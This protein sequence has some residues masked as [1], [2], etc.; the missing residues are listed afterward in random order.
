M[1]VLLG[2][3]HAA[4]APLLLFSPKIFGSASE[5]SSFDLII[6]S[7]VAVCPLLGAFLGAYFCHNQ[8]GYKPGDA[9]RALRSLC[10]LLFVGLLG[11]TFLFASTLPAMRELTP[12]ALAW[13]LIFL[14]STFAPAA[15]LLMTSCPSYHRPASNVMPSMFY[16][17][18]SY[19]I[20]PIIVC[21]LSRIAAPMYAV[22]AHVLI[23]LLCA[24][25]LAAFTYSNYPKVVVPLGLSG[26]DLQREE[27][28]FEISRRRALVGI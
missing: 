1:A 2:L 25:F 24:V 27:I 4:A 14:G 13:V 11:A 12:F 15:G 21:C 5:H 19:V 28:E 9:Y 3:V 8:G 7:I 23:V 16:Q 10:I 22:A 17:V 18:C 26:I 6:C 20:A